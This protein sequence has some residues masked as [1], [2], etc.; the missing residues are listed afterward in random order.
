MPGL[1]SYLESAAEMEMRAVGTTLA[2]SPESWL[3]VEM[4]I[5]YIYFIGI[6]CS[7]DLATLFLLRS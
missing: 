6:G 3:I 2:A 4:W 5:I 7:S 1:N